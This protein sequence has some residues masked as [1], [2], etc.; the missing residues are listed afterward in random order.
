MMTD[1]KISVYVQE[2]VKEKL[3]VKRF[4]LAP[5]TG[6]LTPFGGGSHIA[7]HIPLHK[8][9]NTPLIR[10]YSLIGNPFSDQGLYEIAVKKQDPSGGGSIY[11]HEKVKVGDR[12]EIS[13]PYNYFPLHLE[14]SH[15]VFYAGGIGITPFLA[16]MKQ[17][18]TMDRSFELHYFC[19]SRKDCPFYD[20]LMQLFSAHTHIYFTAEID[21]LE[22]LKSSLKEL[23]EGT[24]LYICGP[25]GMIS[26]VT[27]IA[28]G[29]G[30]PADHIHVERFSAHLP[31]ERHPFKVYLSQSKKEFIVGADT[32][33]LDTLLKHG[34]KIDYACRRGICGTCEVEVEEGKVMHFDSF[35]TEDERKN[36]MLACVSRGCG[37][38]KL[39][40]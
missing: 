39:K 17:L 33:L 4:V 9:S 11:M 38:V 8:G 32:S 35:L 15:H 1:R 16:M 22:A 40:C 12:L 6:T 23:P 21:K 25:S 3:N 37:V 10:H 19:R 14:A 2:I 31:E 26:D 28:T 27:H 7:V 34:I 13:G 30:F 5:V 29:T 36:K 24:H 20:E 18:K